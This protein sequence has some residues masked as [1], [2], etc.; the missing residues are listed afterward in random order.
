MTSRRAI[1]W[2]IAAALAAMAGIEALFDVLAERIQA[3][4][5]AWGGG[6]VWR[7][8]AHPTLLDLLDLPLFVALAFATAA[9]LGRRLGIVGVV[10]G[11]DRML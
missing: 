4:R 1:F 9:W 8:L 7:W 5:P 11:S 6:P 10:A 2:S 3:A